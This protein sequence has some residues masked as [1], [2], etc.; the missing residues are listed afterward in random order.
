MQ[1]VYKHSMNGWSQV[2]TGV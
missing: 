2:I 1:Y